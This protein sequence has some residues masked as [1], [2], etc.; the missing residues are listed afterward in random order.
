MS[1]III[2]DAEN[3]KLLLSLITK[4]ILNGNEGK[5]FQPFMEGKDKSHFVFMKNFIEQYLKIK[6]N[7][8]NHGVWKRT[9]FKENKTY[10]YFG[11]NDDDYRD[12][13]RRSLFH[14]AL[15]LSTLQIV[16]F[17]IETEKSNK[18]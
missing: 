13:S 4:E 15:S 2:N 10:P 7:P 14:R 18:R 12:K 16:Q 1:R 9:Q 3:F 8:Y 5:D 11:K 17:L 6:G